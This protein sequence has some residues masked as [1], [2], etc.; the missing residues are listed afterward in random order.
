MMEVIMLLTYSCN[1]EEF[2]QLSYTAATERSSLNS[3]ASQI[4]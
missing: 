2:S 3:P 1:I 4:L